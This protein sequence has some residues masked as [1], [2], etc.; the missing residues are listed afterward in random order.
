M[1]KLLVTYGNMWPLSM[2]NAKDVHF[3]QKRGTHIWDGDE[4]T[5]QAGRGR[6]GVHMVMLDGRE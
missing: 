5:T 2:D 4:S 3:V 1:P 6:F